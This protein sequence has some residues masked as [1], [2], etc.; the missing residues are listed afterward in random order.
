M[1]S[2]AKPLADRIREFTLRTFIEPAVRAIKREIKIRAGDIHS[3]MRLHPRD[4]R[5]N[6]LR[7]W[8]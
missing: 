2:A 6:R 8:D 1:N 3:A 5:L 7:G 4:T